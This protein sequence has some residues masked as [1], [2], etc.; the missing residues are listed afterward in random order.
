MSLPIFLRTIVLPL[1]VSFPAIVIVGNV[2][3][4]LI[5]TKV[6]LVSVYVYRTSVIP[7]GRARLI[8]PMLIVSLVDLC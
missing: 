7:I 5:G 2:G 4:V 1:E 6:L 3:L 8:V